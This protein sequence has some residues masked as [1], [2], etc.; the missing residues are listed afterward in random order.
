MADETTRT[1]D[2]RIAGID[3]ATIVPA[4]LVLALAVLMGVV[5]PLLDRRASYRDTV[6]RGDLVEIADGITLVP[7]PGWSLASGALVGRTR[8][9]VGTTQ[10]TEV[11]DGG[12]ELSVQAA[13]FAGDASALLTRV[14]RIGR[15]LRHARG[16]TAT[17]TDRYRV[18][19][20]QGLAGV[21]EDFAG[22]TTVGSVVAFVVRT[23][24][25]PGGSQGQPASEGV[26]VVVAGP[27]DSMSRRRG[28]VVAMIRSLR[29]AS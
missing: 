19:T 20:R 4:L 2:R 16:R 7:A 22:S 26:E 5:F 15:E 28:A 9:Q 27:R 24:A 23:R 17:A 1:S 29:A 8:S 25:V 11:V 3:R 12:V 13:P 18:T 10:E 14:I 6:H 21:G